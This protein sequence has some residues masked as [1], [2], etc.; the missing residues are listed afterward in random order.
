MNN[1]PL[2]EFNT[3]IGFYYYPDDRHY[4]AADLQLWLPRLQSLGASWLTLMASPARAVPEPFVRGLIEAGIEP[5]IHMP[6]SPI[7]A[8]DGDDIKTLYQSYA[9]WGAHYVVLYDQP[10]SRSAWTVGEWGREGL[11]GRFLDFVL[12]SLQIAQSVG[13]MPVFPPLRQGGDYWDTSFLDA[14]IHTL[15]KRGQTSVLQE[16]VFAH[17]AF[18]G[19]RPP[20]WGAGGS[21]RWTTARPYSTPPGAQDQ[22]GFRSFEWY[23][24]IIRARLDELRPLLMVAGGARPG[25]A[26]DAN[27]PP[28]DSARH[29]LCNVNTAKAMIERTLPAYLLNVSYWLLAAEPQSASAPAAWYRADDSALPA[30][31]ALADLAAAALRDVSAHEKHASRPP[32]AAAPKN[33]AKAIHHYVLL[34]TFEWGISDWHWLAAMEYVRHFRPTCGFSEQEAAAAEYV[35][36]IGNEQG[37][38]SEAENRLRAAGCRV[39][40]VCGDNGSDTQR[41]LNEMAKSG[42]RFLSEEIS[43]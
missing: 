20:D 16:M 25:D 12:P 13:L 28:V 5:I 11:V 26:N 19:N 1:V 14:A 24:E 37:V 18:A 36:I 35:T 15:L 43:G 22:R 21:A 33:S 7:Q 27:Y 40:R 8:V 32:A 9:R 17:Y 39:E 23:A 6:V 29:A 34:P 2:P 30:V 41:R 38:S 10:N 4:R 3:G 42:R 31:E